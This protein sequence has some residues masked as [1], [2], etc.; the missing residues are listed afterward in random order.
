MDTKDTRV[1]NLLFLL[2]A[3]PIGLGCI[4]ADDD[5]ETTAVTSSNPTSGD[6]EVTSTTETPSTESVGE[7]TVGP[8]STDDRGETTIVPEDTT[9]TPEDTTAGGDIPPACQSYGDAIETCFAGYG[10]DAATSCATYHA[11][12]TENY[13]AECIA[14]FEDWLACL[15]ALSCEDLEMEE[16][17]ACAEAVTARDTACAP[18]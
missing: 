3:A 10:A 12:Y 15:S 6:T 5:G 11:M 18:A 14:A 2:S 16:P 7:T 17:A 13:G 1:Q 4:I 9:I 8:V